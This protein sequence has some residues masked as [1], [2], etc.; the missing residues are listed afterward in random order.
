MKEVQ[1]ALVEANYDDKEAWKVIT[2]FETEFV[3]KAEQMRRKGESFDMQLLSQ[4]ATK[5]NVL[6]EYYL[7][8][9]EL[10]VTKAKVNFLDEAESDLQEGCHY[11]C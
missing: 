9:A 1:V 2:K 3:A 5:V 7:E 4:T 6:S 10:N 8:Q 11:E